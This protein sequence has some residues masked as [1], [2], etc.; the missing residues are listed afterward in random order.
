M[1]NTYFTSVIDNEKQ[2]QNEERSFK[3]CVSLS[4]TILLPYPMTISKKS[5]KSSFNFI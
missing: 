2:L 5:P 4:R 1:S 3:L